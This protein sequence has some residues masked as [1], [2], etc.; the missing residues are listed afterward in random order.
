M[1]ETLY[2]IDVAILY[3]VNK[4]LANPVL[5]FLFPIITNGRNWLPIYV[6]AIVLL[7]WKGGT[8]GRICSLV[9][10]FGVLISDQ[11]NSHFLKEIFLRERPCNVFGDLNLLIGH[12]GGKSF[13]SS[14]SVNNFCAAFSLG[15]FYSK[16]KY[17]FYSIAGIIAFTRVY[18]GVHY[19]SDVIVGSLLGIFL[20]YIIIKST[21]FISNRIFKYDLVANI[22]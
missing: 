3:F 14:H 2:S 6:I 4:A 15:F 9:L 21:I 17:I 7:L 18:L 8:K 22:K 19:P 12:P 20:G 1:I 16:R 11:T 5:D 10:L 13:P